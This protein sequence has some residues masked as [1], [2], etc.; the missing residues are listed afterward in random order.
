MNYANEDVR[1]CFHAN[2]VLLQTIC[3]LLESALYGHAYQLTV[4]ATEESDGLHMAMLNVDSTDEELESNNMVM[5][6]DLINR[7]F[8]R[9]DGQLTVKPEVEDY[10]ILSVTVT[11]AADF[12]L[13]H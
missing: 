5:A 7:Q 10:S 2:S 9:A 12:V 8:T 13:L 1:K 4:F 6:V 3:Q 11:A